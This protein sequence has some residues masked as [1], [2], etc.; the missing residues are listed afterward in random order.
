MTQAVPRYLRSGW[1]PPGA[2]QAWLVLSDLFIQ[3]GI[4]IGIEIRI[5][6]A[7]LVAAARLSLSLLLSIPAR[8][9]GIYG[10]G[11]PSEMR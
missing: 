10:T 3:I 4:E 9:L 8:R 7:S 6:I 11:Y 1:L 2:C 5:E